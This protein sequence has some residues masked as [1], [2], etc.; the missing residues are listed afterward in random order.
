MKNLKTL[1]I[2]SA[3]TTLA[4]CYSIRDI[5]THRLEPT[6]VRQCTTSYSTCVNGG[7]T[8]GFKTEILK[9]CQDAFAVCANTCPL[10]Q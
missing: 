6:C 2:L 3:L 9:A 1:L 10:R 5:D 8:F 4:G 7:P